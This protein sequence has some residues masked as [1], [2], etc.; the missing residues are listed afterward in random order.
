MNKKKT[1]CW[2]IM[3]V[4]TFCSSLAARLNNTVGFRVKNR[5]I[6]REILARRRPHNS[7]HEPQDTPRGTSLIGNCVRDF[8][9]QKDLYTDF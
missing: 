3:K 8:S 1:S 6:Y 9:E 2:R 7:N 5:P 4:S